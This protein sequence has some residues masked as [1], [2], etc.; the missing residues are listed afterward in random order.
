MARARNRSAL[1][2]HGG[3]GSTGPGAER[4]ER[5]RAMMAAMRLGAGI[6]RGNGSALEA[7]AFAILGYQMLRGRQG[8]IPTVTGARAPAVLGKLTLSPR[9]VKSEKVESGKVKRR[10]SPAPR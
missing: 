1:V 8:N 10:V 5:R 6:L 2:A 4:T 9:P 7:V 3:A